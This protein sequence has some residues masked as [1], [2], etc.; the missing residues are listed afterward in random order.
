MAMER[1]EKVLSHELSVIDGAGAGKRQENVI[2]GV[3][4]P[5][6]GKGPRY[7]LEGY[8]SRPF[9]R[10][11]SNGYLG[12]ALQGRVQSAGED[13]VKRFGAG[14]G[15]VRFISGT[16]APHVELEERLARFHGRQAGMIFSSAYAT[17]MAVLPVLITDRTAVISDELNHNCIINATRLAR[18]QLKLVYP[19]GNLERL[20][21]ALLVPSWSPTVFSA[22]AA[23][24]H[25]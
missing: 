5:S 23:I 21:H 9:L 17:V 3:L 18:P 6:G 4:P 8:G 12:M 1:L 25:R 19:H 20:E 14:P 22:C 15:A 10:M 2:T 13:A 16:Y 24:M 7:L 11:N